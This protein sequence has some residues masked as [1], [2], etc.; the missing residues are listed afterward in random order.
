MSGLQSCATTSPAGFT[1]TQAVPIE[2]GDAATPMR[3][4]KITR[5]LNGILYPDHLA[6][7]KSANRP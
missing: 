2:N 5:H 6:A 4:F 7:H 1:R 3:I